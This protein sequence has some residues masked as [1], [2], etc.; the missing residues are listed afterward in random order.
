MHQPTSASPDYQIVKVTT[1]EPDYRT[2]KVT[3]FVPDEEYHHK[4]KAASIH[5]FNNQ[6][7]PDL[8]SSSLPEILTKLQKSNHLPET[9]MPDNVD[10]SIKTLVK[11]LNKIKQKEIV[12]KPP[13]QYSNHADDDY[14][15][16]NDDDGNLQTRPN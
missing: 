15:Y 5:K 13:P 14:D 8:R 6:V 7:I 11:I 3:T 16:G 1:P 9:L 10:N 4:I 12:H 2:V